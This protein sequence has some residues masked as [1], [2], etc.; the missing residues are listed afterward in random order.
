MRWRFTDRLLGRGHSPLKVLLFFL[1]PALILYLAFVIYPLIDVFRLSLFQWRGVT[2]GAEKFVGLSNFER[3]IHDGVFWRSLGNNMVLFILVASVSIILA[4]FFAYFLAQKIR[5][6]GLYRAT[7]LF[8]NM[9]GDVVVATI[10]L[11]IY[12]PTVGLLNYFL[13]S[14]GLDTASFP[15]LG[16][17]DTALFA[18]AFPMI[19]KFMGLYIILFLAAMQEIPQSLLDAAK[20][21]GARRWQ[22]FFHIVLPLLRPTIGVA[23]VF[24]AYNSFNVIFTY[25]K[26]MTEGGPYR[27]TEVLP[28]YIYQVAFSYNEFGYASAISVVTILILV[29]IASVTVRLL[30]RQFVRG[31]RGVI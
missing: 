7:W 9:L 14:I 3:L 25:V 28:T 20:V 24:F 5:L 16:R 31:K 30:M 13:C 11:F 4:L 12:N 29:V 26:I 2:R 23:T 1:G 19:W 6:A 10:W 8:P 21:D 15:W 22:E 18:V 17:A 27:S